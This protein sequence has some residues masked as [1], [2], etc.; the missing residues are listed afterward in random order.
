VDA[1][2]DRFAHWLCATCGHGWE[3]K[4]YARTLHDSGCPM[5]L[6]LPHPG[7]S[8]AHKPRKRGG[9]S[10]KAIQPK[11]TQPTEAHKEH[12]DLPF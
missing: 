5:W 1:G 8:D 6:D 2:A 3:A 9:R 7:R 11:A 4:I 10:S 12:P